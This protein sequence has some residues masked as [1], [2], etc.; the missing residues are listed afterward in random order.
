MWF[1]KT[2]PFLS[3]PLFLACSSSVEQR[4]E[5]SLQETADSLTFLLEPQVSVYNHSLFL[6]TDNSGKEFIYL[7]DGNT[8]NV[9]LYNLDSESVQK[10]VHYESDGPN[11][12]G[13]VFSCIINKEGLLYFPDN[14][15]PYV[16]ILNTDGVKIGA[17]DLSEKDILPVHN[18]LYNPIVLLDDKLYSVQSPRHSRSGIGFDDSPTEVSISIKDLKV[19]S[20]PC[21][22]PKKLKNLVSKSRTIDGKFIEESRCYDGEKFIYSFFGSEDLIVMS[23]DFSCVETKPAGSKFI[24][25][26]SEDVI[27]DNDFSATMRRACT[28]A[29]YGR[30]I[31]DS[32][33]KVYYRFAYPETELDEK[34][35]NWYDLMQS[36]RNEFS[37]IVLDEDLNVI[38]ETMFPRDRFRSN[39]YFVCKDGFYI[40]CNHYK[41]PG[42]TDDKLQFVKF[43]LKREYGTH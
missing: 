32:Y 38:G 33:R 24:P 27:D 13:R 23:P 5:V 18:E 29:H 8:K 7:L 15:V 10:V 1:I 4:K 9:Y 25:G 36:G 22:L 16:S 40:S 28:D 37:I 20:S 31:Y 43:E 39:L 30:I 41:N 3:I 2:L 35:P 14:Q 6:S 34:E 42:F 12:V 21:L 26:I 11:G 17:I 19:D